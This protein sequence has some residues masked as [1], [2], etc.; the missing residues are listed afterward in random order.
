MHNNYKIAKVYAEG[1]FEIAKTQNSLNEINEQ[2]HSIKNLLKK[3]PEFYYFLVNPLISQQIKKNAIRIIFKKNLDKITLNF[4]LILIERRRIIYFY[5]IIDQ[6]I[7]IWNKA[8]NT[9]IVEISSVIELTEKQKQYL[10]NK[11]KEITKA[12]YIE[13]KLK[14]DTS[15]I[16]GLVIKFGSNL[17]DLSL[18]GQLEKFALYLGIN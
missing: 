3:M 15:L 18:R 14:I 9:R 17:I 10:I 8:T 13:L 16:G 6:F 7:L 5:D 12:S 1:L 2:L 11:L 4:L